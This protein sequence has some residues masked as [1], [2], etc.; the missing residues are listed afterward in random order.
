MPEH[1]VGLGKF[2]FVPLVRAQGS[3]IFRDAPVQAEQKREDQLSHGDGVFAGTVADINSP[4]AGG[5][6]I[7]RVDAGARAQHERQLRR[8]V[9][10]GGGDLFAAHDEDLGF[11]DYPRQLVGF[12]PWIVRDIAAELF[13]PVQMRFGELIGNKNFHSLLGKSQ[14]SVAQFFDK[15]RKGLPRGSVPG[16][17][18]G[19]AQRFGSIG[20]WL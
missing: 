11:C 9:Q 16:M 3:D 4:G 13:K 6:D 20:Q 14:G 12:G 18:D 1:A 7:N 17:S 10:R 19:D 15:H 2:I 5:F 8:S